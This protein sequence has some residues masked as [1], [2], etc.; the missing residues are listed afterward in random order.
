MIPRTAVEVLPSGPVR[1][2]LRAPASKSVTNRLLVIAALAEGRSVLRH[3][4][5]SDDTQAMRDAVSAL[6]SEVEDTPDGW[7]VVGTGGRLRLAER[8]DARLSGTTLRFVTAMAALAGG[9]VTVTGAPPLLRRPIGPLVAALRVLGADVAD[10]DGLP[11]VRLGGG[12]LKGGEVEVDVSGSSQFASAILLVAP[13][14]AQGVT[15]RT[16]GLAASGYV[17]LTVEL[18]RGWGVEVT[19]RED[20][21][22]EVAPGQWYV[23]RDETVEYDAS[24]AAHLLALA[25][26]T[27]GQVTV[28]N[29]VAGTRQ[30]DAGLAG[31]LERMGCVVGRARDALTV[32][33]PRRLRPVDVDLRAM[34]DQVTTV[35]ALAALAEGTS[36]IRGVAVARGHETDRLAALARE[37]RRLG[38]A[39]RQL[40]DG[41]VITGGAAHGPA[42]LATHDDHRLAMAFAAIGA[43]V[44]GVVVEEPW[45]VKK[46]YPDFWRDLADAGVG[47][48]KA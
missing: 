46:T 36:R 14:A 15:L 28:V 24:A 22:W 5:D 18:M 27:G 41:L 13:Y 37:L 39:V 30:P 33:G 40:S 34:P 35:A 43:R 4:L 20:G 38:V 1:A 8:I 31:V 12:G 29:A 47:W 21:S 48:R 44:C 2:M 7:R 23:A 32:T 3:P 19:G 26:A 42:R 16:T 9:P 11:P 6:G 10:G 45:C 25:A 17:Q